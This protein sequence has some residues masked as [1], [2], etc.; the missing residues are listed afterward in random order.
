MQDESSSKEAMEETIWVTHPSWRMHLPVTAVCLGASALGFWYA[1][2]LMQGLIDTTSALP[3]TQQMVDTGYL[4]MKGIVA[5]PALYCLARIAALRLTCFELTTQRLRV[6]HGLFPR[7]QDEIALQR[8]RDYVVKRS[9][10]GMVLGYGTIKL[11][12][13]D[14]IHPVMMMHGI[15]NAIERCENVRACA[16]EWKKTTGYRE[17]ESGAMS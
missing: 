13:R 16:L 5:L 9:L 1:G 4:V 11:L 7:R 3:W 6:R 2:P 17:F 8:M 14:P 12:S 10:A 15:T